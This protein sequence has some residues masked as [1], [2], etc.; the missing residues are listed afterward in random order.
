[1]DT[2][3]AQPPSAVFI[4]AGGV[5]LLPDLELVADSFGV[6]E[7]DDE[8]LYHVFFRAFAQH[9]PKRPEDEWLWEAFARELGLDVDAVSDTLKAFAEK[10]ITPWKNGL[11]VAPCA[12]DL[13]QLLDKAGIPSVVVSNADGT[14]AEML[15]STGVCQIGDGELPPVSGIVD[16]HVVGV[17]KPDSRIFRFAREIV[18]EAT[19]QHL[20]L[21][22]AVHIG[23]ALWSDVAAAEHAGIPVIHLDPEG[24]CPSP[25]G[26]AHVQKL[27]EVAALIG[28]DC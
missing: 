27:T 24:A 4:D 8:A 28:L 6:T 7:V 14:I 26:H 23:D 22:D 11:R 13:L 16:S 2:A 21:F 10:Q 19:G 9:D 15:R 5:L 25:Q 3:I 12:K 20:D 17:R 18:E 1:M